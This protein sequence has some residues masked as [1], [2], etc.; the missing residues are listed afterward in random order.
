MKRLAVPLIVLCVGAGLLLV[1]CWRNYL[2]RRD[3]PPPRDSEIGQLLARLSALREREE[4]VDKIVWAKERLAER[5]GALFESLWDG[6]NVA[7]NK[8]DRLASFPIGAM[9]IGKFE[10][11]QKLSHGIELRQPAGSGVVWSQAQWQAFLAD[12]ARAGWELTQAEFRHHAFDTNE[13]GEAKQ[14]RFYFRAD[15]ANTN[16]N[17]RAT[18]EGDIVVEWLPAPPAVKLIDASHLRI[19]SRRGVPPLQQILLENFQPPERGRFIDPL[20][21][22]D[23]DG[24]GL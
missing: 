8:Y 15:V 22:Y 6:L 21:L 1:A 17:E 3:S 14:S 24:D 13:N 11:P 12:S 18:L 5:Y 10:A 20:I 7:T 4:E 16:A 19:K 9:A 2:L 23:L